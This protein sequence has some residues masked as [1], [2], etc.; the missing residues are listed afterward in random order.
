MSKSKKIFAMWSQLK[1]NNT[2]W[3]VLIVVLWMLGLGF[4]NYANSQNLARAELNRNVRLAEDQSRILDAQV[5]ELQAMDRIENASQRLNLVKVDSR[6][7]IYIKVSDDKV[8]LK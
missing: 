4:S 6:D 2:L 1:K 7:I 5:S 3:A 8:A